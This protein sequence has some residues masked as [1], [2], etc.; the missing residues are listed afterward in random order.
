MLRFFINI[1][2]V[3]AVAVAISMQDGIVHLVRGDTSIDLDLQT[4]L[5]LLVIFILWWWGIAKMW[6]FIKYGFDR[7][8]ERR[9]R[10]Q[11]EEGVAA[12][13]VSLN[14]LAGGDLRTSNKALHR[15]QK[16]LGD[17]PLVLWLGAELATRR[18]DEKL[19][20]QNFRQLASTAEGSV[21]GWR[22]LL[23]QQPRRD[24]AAVLRLTQDALAVDAIAKQDF[25]YELQIMAYAQQ[26]NWAEAAVALGVAQKNKAVSRAREQKLDAVINLKLADNAHSVENKR[27]HF[28]RAQ[29]LLPDFVPAAIAYA[30]FLAMEGD[31]S[32]A[33]KVISTAWLLTPHLDLLDA[34]QEIN[35]VEDDLKLLQMFERFAAKRKDSVATPIALGRLSLRAKLDARAA[36]YAQDAIDRRATQEACMLL[37]DAMRQTNPS[38]AQEASHRAMAAVAVGSYVCSACGYAAPAWQAVCAHCGK[39]ASLD[40]NDEPDVKLPVSTTPVLLR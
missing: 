2:L 37:A 1:I 32:L 17:K 28:A 11:T 34:Y 29:K 3:C 8:Y 40:W 10:K 39:V 38:A 6:F 23:Q 35:A 19:A 14:A 36:A 20:L 12:F 13:T 33:N 4:A 15:A 16:L 5:A 9:L 31:K 26:G 25:A 27:K 22:G 24:S 7:I 30:R 18:G 21:L